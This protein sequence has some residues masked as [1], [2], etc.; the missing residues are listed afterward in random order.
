MPRISSPHS[1]QRARPPPRR[2]RPLIPAAGRILPRM[3]Y[4]DHFATWLEIDL[5]A[6]RENIK[7]CRELTGV[8]IMAVVKANAYGHGIAPV[9]M[10]ALEAG[11]EW[12]GVAR[13]E[14]ALE[15]RQAGIEGPVLVL[16]ATPAEMMREAVASG[17]SLAVWGLEQGRA[18]EAAGGVAR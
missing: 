18:A 13:V 12:C 10:A 9:S 1:P 3:S 11:A 16:G 2:R 8:Q 14:E 4:P 6:I 7:R 5:G 15:L 17:I